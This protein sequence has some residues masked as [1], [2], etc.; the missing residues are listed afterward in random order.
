MEPREVA[1]P[2]SDGQ[3][4]DTLV[5]DL[6]GFEGPI[7][8]LLTLAREQKVDLKH[9]S[10]LALAEQFLAFI[11]QVR[12]HQLELAADYLVMAA[13]LAYLKS[14]LLLPTLAPDDEPSGPEM[15]AALQFQLMRLQAIQERGL[16]L[17][18]RPRLGRD[19]F[20]RGTPEGLGVV[21]RPVFNVTLYDLLKAYGEHHHRRSV[22]SLEIV[23]SGL[24]SVEEAL[25]RLA[26]RVG[27]L[28]GWQV[29]ESFLPEGLSF[30]DAGALLRRSALCATFVAS[31]EL[32]RQGRIEIRQDGGPFSPIHIRRP[33]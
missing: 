18:E 7:D 9:V 11:A 31:L 28:P 33:G 17:M 27:R 26:D 20:A 24:Y 15:A 25:R 21:A 3:P 12:R 30:G 22:T 4:P 2:A 23:P 8:V 32:A 1:A 19:F 13:W 29:L 5:L 14:R 16:A 6:D 10:I